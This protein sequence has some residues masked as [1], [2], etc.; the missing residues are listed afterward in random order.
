[1]TRDEYLASI[2][3]RTVENEA[4]RVGRMKHELAS[5]QFITLDQMGGA[6]FRRRLWNGEIIVLKEVKVCTQLWGGHRG[7]IDVL[8]I[9]REKPKPFRTAL[10]DE[11]GNIIGPISTVSLPEY[12]IEILDNK[13]SWQ[14]KH[15]VQLANYGL[16]FH[17]STMNLF[18]ARDDEWFRI[19]PDPFPVINIRCYM[20][21]FGSDKEYPIPSVMFTMRNMIQDWWRPWVQQV[22]KQSKSKR[23]LHRRGIYLKDLSPVP[24]PLFF[25]KQQL[26]VK[27]PPPKGPRSNFER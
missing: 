3:H 12:H 2:T 22:H 16:V 10:V 9:R 26:L 14:K 20:K 11:Q 5:A 25:G 24:K 1:M 8:T 21:V 7:T 15:F 23:K 4:M 19:Y 18:H 27:T 13:S 17:Q 6:V